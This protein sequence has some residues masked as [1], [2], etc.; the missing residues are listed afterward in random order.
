MYRFGVRLLAASAWCVLLLAAGWF[1]V[2]AAT[3]AQAQ[4]TVYMA[5]GDSVAAGAGASAL[6][7]RY[8]ERLQQFFRGPRTGAITTAVN[9][10][11]SGETSASFIQGT[12][13]QPGAPQLQAALDQINNPANDVNIV[14]LTLGGNDLLQ[15][16][17]PGQP[18]ADPESPGCPPAVQQALTTFAG[19]Y[20]SIMQ[21]LMQALANDP[22]AE[23]VLVM[24]YY[25]PASGTGSP[26]EPLVDAA[27]LGSDGRVDCTAAGAARGLNDLIACTNAAVGARTVDVYPLFQGKGLQL[28]QVSQGSV[29]P[30][31]AGHGVIAG[32]FITAAGYIFL[33]VVSR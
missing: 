31:D 26:Y 5:L 15:L 3:R 6:E 22:G 18:C 4:P 24:T 2:R 23:L 14:T 8:T 30:N 12:Q 9:F 1:P 27:L 25:N 32:A 10:A 7:Y 33:P 21:Q 29:H 13:G 20:A 28:T 16:L 17:A 19:N 11:R